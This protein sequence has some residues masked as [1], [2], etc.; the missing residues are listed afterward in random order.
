M[1]TPPVPG[2]MELFGTPWQEM[3][4]AGLESF[5]RNLADILECASPCPF[6]GDENTTMRLSFTEDRHARLQMECKTCEGRGPRVLTATWDVAALRDDMWIA[7]NAWNRL[8]VRK[9][10]GDK[11]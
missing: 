1:T 2:W 10:E 11:P 5:Q 6:C 9:T 7:C 8:Y 3:R 4:D